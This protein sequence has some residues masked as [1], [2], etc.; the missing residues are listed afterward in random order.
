MRSL[1][2]LSVFAPLLPACTQP[3]CSSGDFGRA[4]CRYLAENELARL[5]PSWHPELRFQDVGAEDAGSWSPT[6]LLRSTANGAVARPAGIGDFALSIHPA[7]SDRD[8]TLDLENLPP[9][10]ELQFGPLGAESPLLAPP[11]GLRRTVAIPPSTEVQWLR[12]RRPCP[13]RFRVA[14]LGDIQTNPTQFERILE[15][16]AQER[17]AVA[18][19]EPVLGLVVLGDL[20][21]ASTEDEF[22]RLE[23]LLRDAPVPVAATAGNHDIYDD[24][25]G[26]YNHRFGPGNFTTSLCGARFVLLDT[27]N[28]ALA[29]SIE[30]ALPSLLDRGPDTWLLAGTHYPP[31]A[32]RLGQGWGDEQQAQ[33][34]LAEAA[35][36]AADLLLAGHVHS[37]RAYDDLPAGDTTIDEVISGT[38]GAVQG[39]GVERFG[40]TRLQ[41]GPDGLRACFQEVPPPGQPMRH[42]Q[43]GWAIRRCDEE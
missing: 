9:D 38:A 3:E 14:V 26:L 37:W 42:G 31:Y 40:Y 27:G 24:D 20:T 32:D 21:E 30:A 12:G 39:E 23:A 36:Q 18:A 43:T 28:G 8:L 6:G 19:T 11:L 34:L 13:S 33:Y 4:E 25:T 16:L 2:L 17:D 22:L 35:R 1:P 15:A 41:F 29:P 7:E 5:A 10:M